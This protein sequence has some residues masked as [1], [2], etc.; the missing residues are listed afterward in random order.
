MKILWFEI[1]TPGKFVGSKVPVNGWQDALESYVRKIP[2][3]QLSIAF[4]GKG[5]HKC[6]DGIDYY[7]IDPHFSLIERIKDRYSMHFS[8]SRILPLAMNVVRMVNPDLIHV[9]GSEYCWGH[10]ALLTDIPIVVH[11]QG[12]MPSYINAKYP[13]GYNKWDRYIFEHFNPAKII[14]EKLVDHYD[15]TWVEQELKNF[16]VVNHYMGRTDWDR[17]LVKLFNPK[18]TYYYCS[19]ALRP[20]ISES[21]ERWCVKKRNH[22]KLITVG[23]GTLW[24]GLDTILR[25][26]KLLKQNNVD[27]EWQVVGNMYCKDLVE[28]KEGF[29]YEDN[30]V[31][32]LGYVG[33]SDLKELLLNSDLYIHTAYIDNSPNSICE[34]QY[35]GVPII[36]TNVGGIPS[37]ID[38]GKNG[39]LVPANDPY[40][41]CYEIQSLLKDKDKQIQLSQSAYETARHR[42]NENIIVNDLLNCYTTILKKYEKQES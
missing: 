23:C 32:V 31:N 7:P 20:E 39:L 28:H 41:M 30:N 19:E 27:F 10:L 42:H 16:A 29:T 17:K 21:K 3:I 18:A 33:P 9:F 1:S 22:Y 15:K 40:I 36:S 24:K 8:A 35:M 13:P 26:A 37:L 34:A 38:S 4:L 11:M 6:I 2:E 12:S 5:C 14:R 25:V